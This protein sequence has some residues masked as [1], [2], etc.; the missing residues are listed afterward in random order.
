MSSDALAHGATHSL[1]VS[2]S[3]CGAPRA[4]GPLS[5]HSQAPVSDPAEVGIAATDASRPS[6]GQLA[7]PAQ[8]APERTI[9]QETDAHWGRPH[10][11]SAGR[12]H[13]VR[14]WP[15]GRGS[16]AATPPLSAAVAGDGPT[17]RGRRQSG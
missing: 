6:G 7:D 5:G 15:D 11:A 13:L 12:R 3:V 14:D 16:G 4:A 8:D 2:P 10:R 1:K 9:D 17:G